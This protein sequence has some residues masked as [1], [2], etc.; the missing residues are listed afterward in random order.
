MRNI[1]KKTIKFTVVIAIPALAL[2][3]YVY[4]IKELFNLHIPYI[5]LWHLALIF[6]LYNA[7]FYSY[8]MSKTTIFS[9]FHISIVQA[10]GI[11]IAHDDTPG[12]IQMLI[13]CIAIQFKYKGLFGKQKPNGNYFKPENKF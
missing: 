7:L 4:N 1:L 13:G 10:F 11:F 12:Q 9:R 8:H 3:F 6:V 2:F 5:I